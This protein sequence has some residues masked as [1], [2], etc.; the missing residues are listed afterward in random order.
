MTKNVRRDARAGE[1][2]EDGRHR[3]AHHRGE[4]EEDQPRRR[5]LHPVHHRRKPE[6]EGERREHDHPLQRADVERVARTRRVARRPAVGAVGDQ[7]GH[8]EADRHVVVDAEHE[9]AQALV[10][11]LDPCAG[12]DCERQSHTADRIQ[13]WKSLLRSAPP[14]GGGR[15]EYGDRRPGHKPAA[16]EAGLREFNLPVQR[17]LR[18]AAG[19]TERMRQVPARPRPSVTA[20][21]VAT[22]VAATLG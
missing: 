5:R 14:N 21:A 2:E 19:L 9:G 15:R 10:D 4:G 7:P 6:D 12:P 22:A 16:P 13:P 3:K 17:F 8:R 11:P 1:H 20:S 18:S